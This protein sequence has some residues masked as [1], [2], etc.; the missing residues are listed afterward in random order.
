V[1]YAAPTVALQAMMVPLLLYLPPTYY[2]VGV[3]LAAT[4]VGAMFVVGRAF[5]AL[6]DPLIGALSDRTRSRFGRRRVWMALGAPIALGSAWFLLTPEAGVGA[7]YLLASLLVFYFGW[8]LVYIPHLAWGTELAQDYHERTRIA[9]YRETGAFVGYLLAAVVPLVYWTAIRGNPEPTPEQ[10]VQTV[11]VLFAIV[12]PIGV[13]LC[14]AFVPPGTNAHADES[15]PWSE[16]CSILRRNRPFARLGL[17]YLFDR[18]AMGTYFAAQPLLIIAALD[19]PGALLWVALA[20]T[21]A[22]AALAPSWVAISHRFGKHRTYVLANLLTMLSYALLFVVQ[23]GQLWLLL[24][25]NVLM[26]FGNGGTMIT[27]PAMTADA[28]DY[29]ELKSRVSQVGGHMAFLAFVFKAGMALGPAVGLGFVGLFGFEQLG[30]E[31]SATTQLGIR[32]CASWL[33]IVLLVP[34]V[35]LMWQF[36]LD[37]R[38]HGIIRG[39]LERLR[40]REQAVAAS[41]E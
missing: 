25:A 27:P 41:A 5:E 26:G 16:L 24:V 21:V 11:G 32:L 38:R 36:P 3:G 29:D 37:A 8:T 35:A 13:A 34:A 7:G 12:L 33:P 20:N 23:P 4:V 30:R 28:A 6:T 18:L 2:S 1:A 17:A 9:G 14:F 39:R 10:I 15:T 22:A 31:L 19:M 40:R